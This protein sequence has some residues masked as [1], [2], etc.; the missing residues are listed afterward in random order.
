MVFESR[1]LRINSLVYDKTC[2]CT[3]KT[4]L[5]NAEIKPNPFHRV[6]FGRFVRL[7]QDDY[8]SVCIIYSLYIVLI[9]SACT[10]LILDLLNLKDVYLHNLKYC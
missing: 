5:L 10:Y 1:L 8:L 3:T 7:N 4:V 6:Y 9:E 2:N